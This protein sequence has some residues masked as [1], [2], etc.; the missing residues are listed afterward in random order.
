MNKLVKKGKQKNNG[1]T[2][3]ALVITIIVLLILAG[4][5][6]STLTGDSGILTKVQTAKENTVV[7]TE[8]EQIKTAYLAAK[9]NM[10]GD[11]VNAAQ[12]KKELDNLVGK[13]KTKVSGSTKIKVHFVDTDNEYMITN[14]VVSEYQK[15]EATSVY[16][17]VFDTNGDSTGDLFVLSSTNDY[18]DEE[19][20]TL[21]TNY[22]NKDNTEKQP[23]GGDDYWDPI[24]YDNQ[25]SNV[26]NVI[27][28]DNI[29]PKSCSYW[30]CEGFTSLKEI[31]NIENLDTS[32][33]ENMAYMFSGCR[34]LTSLNV[35]GFDT[36]NAIVMNH[37]FNRCSQLTSIDVS[38]FDTSKVT[39][40]DY[41]FSECSQL[42]S[43]DVSGLDTSNVENMAYMFSGCRQLTSL[44]V[45]NFNMSSISS[46]FD[47]AGMFDGVT[48]KIKLGSGWND[49]MKEGSGYEER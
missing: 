41:M 14:G 46:R 47:V 10:L 2:L 35:T 8:E 12:V 25:T 24:W 29:V 49:E 23:T 32:N 5:T 38:G 42:T 15:P 16:A 37:M 40:M 43:I 18:N 45:S 17:K 6:I 20:G 1:I 44:D 22:D 26:E 11:S 34:Q 19:Y 30:F 7:G 13:G 3:I 31:K 4:V 48:C 28:R 33:V 27:I 21:I 39:D 36:S 9:I